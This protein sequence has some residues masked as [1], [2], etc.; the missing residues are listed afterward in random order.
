MSGPPYYCHTRGIV[1]SQSSK[2]FWYIFVIV[3]GFIALHIIVVRG[4]PK[5]ETLPY[6]EFQTHLK[7]GQIAEVRVLKE[8]IEGTFKKPLENGATRF[9]TVRV[10]P[11]LATELASQEVVF[12][13]ERTRSL[14][15]SVVISLLP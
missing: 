2:T 5:T 9:V 8:H 11:E 13:G 3:W 10:P 6:S 7:A 14:W 4:S 15:S 12:S 1:Q